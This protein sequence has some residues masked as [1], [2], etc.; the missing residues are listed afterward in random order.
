MAQALGLKYGPKRVLGIYRVKS[1]P[2]HKSPQLVTS[3]T[4]L[5]TSVCVLDSLGNMKRHLVTPGNTLV[6]PG[7]Y[8][9]TDNLLCL[10][11]IGYRL[12]IVTCQ[13]FLATCDHIEHKIYFI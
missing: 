13:E 11:Q 10:T 4:H 5:V 12:Q 1:A 7:N 8:L 3:N 9:V 6:T 2:G